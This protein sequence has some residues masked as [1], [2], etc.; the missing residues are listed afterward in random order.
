MQPQL[1]TVKGWKVI[2]VWE[3]ELKRR[4]E[5]KLVRRLKTL[6]IGAKT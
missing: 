3:H 4:D 6:L 1:E 2:R 5:A